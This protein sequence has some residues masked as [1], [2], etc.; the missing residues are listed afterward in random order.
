M[1]IWVVGWVFRWFVG[2]FFGGVFVWDFSGIF[3]VFLWFVGGILAVV[4][5]WVLR[6]GCTMRMRPRAPDAVD[7][8]DL[9]IQVSAARRP[10]VLALPS[11]QADEL[12]HA[13]LVPELRRLCRHH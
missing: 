12:E 9:D 11:T 5:S 6:L 2:G 13:E 10:A 8:G 7:V 4:L 1:F 3:G